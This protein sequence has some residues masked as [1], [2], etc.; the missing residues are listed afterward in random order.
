MEAGDCLA[1]AA[2]LASVAEEEEEEEE[3]VVVVVE[4][5]VVVVV[6]G[7][8]NSAISTGVYLCGGAK[9]LQTTNAS[10]LRARL[11]SGLVTHTLPK[12]TCSCAAN[13]S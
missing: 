6:G 10:A 7:A 13:S 4:V 8:P 2:A 12:N 5:V 1:A 9:C 11:E 3:A